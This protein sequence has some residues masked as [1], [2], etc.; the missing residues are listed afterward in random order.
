VVVDLAVGL[1]EALEDSAAVPLAVAAPEEVG[2]SNKICVASRIK[3][4]EE[5]QTV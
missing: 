3:K 5:N 2:K 1:V 4:P